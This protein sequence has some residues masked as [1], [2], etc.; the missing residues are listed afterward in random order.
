[1]PWA[2]QVI[3]SW[4]SLLIAGGLLVVLLGV[5]TQL[6][7]EDESELAKQTQNPVADLVSIPVQSNMNFGLEPNHRT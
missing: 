6:Q 1:M 2:R 3:G 7:A 4:R 5:S